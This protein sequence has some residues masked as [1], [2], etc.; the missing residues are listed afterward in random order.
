MQKGFLR[1]HWQMSYRPHT[2]TSLTND[3]LVGLAQGTALFIA[4][5]NGF[6]VKFV[7]HHGPN[8]TNL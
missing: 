4:A 6:D 3:M 1:K 2:I 5:W 8:L 7:G